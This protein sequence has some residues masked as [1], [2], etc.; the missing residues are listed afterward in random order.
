MSRRG[1]FAHGIINGDAAAHVKVLG[2]IVQASVEVGQ[3]LLSMNS[4]HG[5][6]G[7]RKYSHAKRT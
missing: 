4:R 7:A 1:G 2:Q 6:I 3:L 5:I